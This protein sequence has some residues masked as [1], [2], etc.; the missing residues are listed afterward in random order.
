MCCSEL[1]ARYRDLDNGKGFINL[2]AILCLF[3]SFL[4]SQ[5]VLFSIYNF[6]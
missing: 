3:E 5:K 4:L 2:Q 6:D 1:L